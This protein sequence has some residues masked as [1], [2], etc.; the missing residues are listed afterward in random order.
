MT[1][2]RCECIPYMAHQPLSTPQS[3]PSR[4][5][6]GARLKNKLRSQVAVVV[7]QP[8]ERHQNVHEDAGAADLFSHTQGCR[9]RTDG[10]RD[11]RAVED[12]CTVHI[13]TIWKL[14][15]GR[16]GKCLYLQQGLP[17]NRA[18]IISCF[19][20]NEARIGVERL[21]VIFPPRPAFET[22]AVTSRNGLC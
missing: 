11:F 1:R 15:V 9:F 10:N 4:T 18:S 19:T 21:H 2:R 5:F 7:H 8:S 14:G 20:G 6:L 17:W 12:T 16:R 3:D 13:N 22:V